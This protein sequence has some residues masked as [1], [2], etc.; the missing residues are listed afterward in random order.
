MPL[1]T[2]QFITTSNRTIA[3]VG[4]PNT[5]KT[6]LFNAL[7]GLDQ[8]VGNYAGVTVERK[9]GK[10]SLADGIDVDLLDLPGAY[11]LAANSPDEMIVADVL[12]GQRQDAPDVDVILSIVDATNLRRNLYLLS[13]VMEVGLPIVVALNMSDL[14]Q[15]RQ[16]EIDA[17]TLSQR[18]GVPV[19]PVCA[20][21]RQGLDLLRQA[22]TDRLDAGAVT[23]PSLPRFPQSMRQQVDALVRTVGEVDETAP[24]SKVEALRALVDTD[25]HA[26]NRLQDRLGDQF[27]ETLGG[28]RRA[29]GVTA[30]LASFESESRYMWIDQ[31]LDGC[32]RQPQELQTRPSDRI[33]R[34][35][36]DRLFGFIAFV[37]IS[38]VVFQ[39]IY[40]WSVPLMDGINAGVSSF[41]AVL[42]ATLPEGALRSLVVDGIVAGVGGVL[43]FLPQIAMLFLF[44]SI[45]EDCGYMARAAFLMDRLLSRCGLSGQSFIPLLSSFACAVPGIMAT[46]TI[47]D[48]RDRIAT[49]AVAPLMS[50][51]A[52]LPV[53]VLFIAAFIPDEPV[54]GDWIGLQGL[55]LLSMYFIGVVVAI[56]IAWILKKTVLGGETP[57]LLLELPSYKWP[58]PRT[59]LLRVYQSS[60]A[61][62]V[63]AGT[64]IFAATIVMWAL[65]YFP[66]STT[67]LEKY[68]HQRAQVTASI[69]DDQQR[70][71]A[72]NAVKK[73]QAAELLETSYLGQV[74]HFLEPA[75]RP[76]GWDWRIGMAVIASFP[77]REVI[78]SVLGT[79]YSLGGDLDEESSDLRSALR[80]STWPDGTAVFTIPVALSIMVFFA[81][82]AQCMSTLAVIHRESGS[83]H[84]A[85]FTFIY[86]TLLAY[87]GAF[88]T[89]R[90]GGGGLG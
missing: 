57:A 14:A 64:I 29:V 11:S 65:A 43:V 78:I 26:E 17:G 81:L 38:G 42:S 25:G 49:I 9:I 40:R 2:Q 13:Q 86:M 4:N 30:P 77:A 31:V 32:I 21:R 74:G 87:V 18:L 53:Y 8:R 50:C 7:T 54:V 6:T 33:D 3:V 83:W 1:S 66:R 61:F 60:K 24:L 5:G 19:V 48:R 80:A 22:P 88:V 12:L 23:Y 47:S 72:L 62:V 69:E 79:I 76:L 85:A 55:T 28:I 58:D 41:G 46:R 73:R 44:I 35:L 59:V 70:Q 75:V 20:S 67:V 16:I 45:L 36:T 52:R 89:Y 71:T 84:W 34:I 90:I 63:R 37:L 56:P 10:L 68:E 15:S 51:S 82:C 27:A 39:G